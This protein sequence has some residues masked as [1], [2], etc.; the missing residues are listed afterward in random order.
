MKGLRPISLCNVIY[1]VIAKVL[2]NRLKLVLSGIISDNQ[3]AFVPKRLISDNIIVAYECLHSMNRRRR[4][5]KGF[6]ALKL[7]MSKA[8]DRVEWS[9]L[10]EMMSVMGFPTKFISNIMNCI[11]TV[12]YSVSLNGTRFGNII[13][14]RGLRQGDPL[15]PYLFLIC[16]E[17]LSSLIQTIERQGSLHGVQASRSSPNISHLFFAD[18]SLLFFRATIE[19]AQKIQS[20][21]EI[22]RGVSGQE[23]N[24]DKSGLYFSKNTPR[25]RRLLLRRLLN[26]KEEISIEKYLGLPPMVGKAKR[27][28]FISIKERISHKIEG[29]KERLLSI[30]GK[31][32]MIKAVAQ[33]IPTYAMSI[34]KLPT[35]LCMEIENMLARFWWRNSSTSQGIHWC[36]WSELCKPKS[37]G[38]LGFKSLIIF[39]LALLGKQW[40]R[41]LTDQNSLMYKVLKGRYFP[42]GNIEEAVLG[43]NPSFVWRSIWEA[44]QIV[45]KGF[46]WRIGDGKNI[47]IWKD[48]WIPRPWTFK[49]ISPAHIL[50]ANATVD[51]LINQHTGQWNTLLLKEIFF[52]EDIEVISSITLGDSYIPDKKIWALHH[53]GSYSVRSGYSF[54][55]DLISQTGLHIT[56]ITSQ[57]QQGSI[58]SPTLRI[59]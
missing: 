19:E 48:R 4:G 55:Y 59:I 5:T 27:K 11:S 28:A 15:S 33:A 13:P 38:G 14:Q 18:D 32:I 47:K 8:Y 52:P 45:D 37:Q 31:E 40:W 12:S 35:T 57:S 2:A 51:S 21:L 39:N 22:Y 41:L 46:I 29:W 30:G 9:F 17:G 25:E 20:I 34:F 54:I 56:G 50:D 36:R 24:L 10:E 43:R 44:K 7:D 49:P 23:V 16:A 3:S 1:K 6:C 26:V 58:S 42:S 53:S